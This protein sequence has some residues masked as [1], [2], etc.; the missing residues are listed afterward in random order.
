MGSI[1]SSVAEFVAG[2]WVAQEKLDAPSIT[3]LMML[4]VA[5]SCLMMHLSPLD[6]PA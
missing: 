4:T 2:G 3:P 5:K 1:Q 6:E